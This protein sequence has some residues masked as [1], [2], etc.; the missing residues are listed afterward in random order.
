[1]KNTAI[2]D[3]TNTER[4]SVKRMLLLVIKLSIPAILAQL[5]T[6]VMQYIDAAMV[7]SIGANAS[8]SI[9]LVSTSTWLI[10]GLCSS[11]AIGFSVQ[12]AQ[13]VGSNRNNDARNVFRQSLIICLSFGVFLCAIASIISP[14]LPKWLGGEKEVIADSSKYFLIFALAL[15]ATALRMVCANSLQCSGDMKTPSILNMNMCLLDV[16]F[17]FLLIYPTRS[18]SV[19]GL[20]F[21]MIGAGMGVAGAAL[22]TLIADYVTAILMLLLIIFKSEKLKFKLGGSWR[23]RKTTIKTALRISLPAAFEHS[24]MCTAYICATVITAPLGTVAIA[25]NSL[26]VTAESFCY[27]PGYGIGSASTTLIGQSIGAKRKDLAKRFSR[28]AIALGVI[29]MSAIAVIMYILAPYIFK[30]LSSDPA[31]RELGAKM[32]RIVAFAEP[33]Y[34]ASIVCIGSLRGAGDTFIPG[35]LNLA[36]MWG[37]RITLSFILVPHLQLHG[38]WIAMSVEL[39]FRGIVFLIRTLRGKWLNRKLEM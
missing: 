7:G 12:I 34:A 9:G 20:K 19:F 1:M 32:L 5:T 35:I 14:F 13:L 4:L 21:N 22:G 6:V 17:N 39:C 24:I 25:A 11:L 16:V 27:M 29:V 28:T 8:A 23:I 3:F 2:I 18:V 30:L 36:S 37:V 38:I 33:L 31:V 26:A 10:N 15:P